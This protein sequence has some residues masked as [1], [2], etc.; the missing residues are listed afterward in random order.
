MPINLSGSKI[1][2]GL[3]REFCFNHTHL[4]QA[5][6]LMSRK[7]INYEINLLPQDPFFETHLGRV[8]NWAI[9]IGR[10]ILIFTEFIVIAS[11]GARFTIDRKITDLN[12]KIHQK[13]ALIQS[14]RQFES[15]F[16][17]AQAKIKNYQQIEQQDN[18]VDIFPTL[19]SVVPSDF[20]MNRLTI[21]QQDLS[22]E[23]VALSNRALNYFISNLQLSPYFNKISVSNIESSDRSQ[24]GFAVV[25]SGNYQ[26]A[27]EEEI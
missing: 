4:S 9:N 3:Y 15:T 8:L 11:F 6:C 17:L 7:S 18:L 13:S 26:T 19:Q 20:Y 27:E 14:Q 24:R 25:I 1:Q 22:V 16:R 2:I 10:Y 5:Y 12:N 21:G 23:G